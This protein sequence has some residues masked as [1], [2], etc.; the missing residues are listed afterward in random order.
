M[1][2]SRDDAPT[3]GSDGTET[4]KKR[5]R[6]QKHGQDWQAVDAAMVPMHILRKAAGRG[7]SDFV[8]GWL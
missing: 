1:M 4:Q 3:A 5:K 7:F 8:V 6:K 2:V